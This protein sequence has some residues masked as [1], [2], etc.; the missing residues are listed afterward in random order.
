MYFVI[1]QAQQPC[2]DCFGIGIWTGVSDAFTSQ[3][4]ARQS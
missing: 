1:V 4:T 3:V 2:A